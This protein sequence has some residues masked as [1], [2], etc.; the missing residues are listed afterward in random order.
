MRITGVDI[1]CLPQ[2]IGIKYRGSLSLHL[3][4]QNIHV[5][6]WETDSESPPSERLRLSAGYS[7]AGV[8]QVLLCSYAQLLCLPPLRLILHP[9][10]RTFQAAYNISI[11]IDL[12]LG[13]AFLEWLVIEMHTCGLSRPADL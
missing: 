9:A 13:K 8:A 12:G 2:G 3:D 1:F 7:L 10:S 5:C 4:I 11:T 6:L